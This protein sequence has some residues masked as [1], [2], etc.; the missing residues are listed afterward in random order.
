MKLK[1]LLAAG[2]IGAVSICSSAFAQSSVTLYGLI[3]TG[4]AY[5]TNQSGSHTYQT[6]NGTYQGPR[7]GL[8]GTEDLGGGTSAIFTLENGFSILNGNSLNQGREF[9]RQSFVGLSNTNWGTL[10]LGRQYDSVVDFLGLNTAYNWN[11]TINDNDNTFNNIRVQ[12]ALKYTTQTFK[13]FKAS[14]L[15]GFSNS[16]TGFNNNRAF[17]LG[18]SYTQGPLNWNV[19][20]AEYDSPYS[21]TNQTGAID[22]DYSAAYLTFNRSALKAH[23]YAS[24]QRIFGTGGV[25]SIG[26]L[27]LGALYTD[28]NYTYL[29]AQHLNV[30][31]F[32]L[33]AN[34]F[35]RPDILL[36]A[37][38][39]Y[40]VGQYTITDQ[41]PKWNEVNLVADYI[42]SKRTDIALMVYLQQ[43]GGGARADIE[44]YYASTT[45][46][47]LVTT[48]G[49]RHTF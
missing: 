38:Y 33:S 45:N 10:T 25:Y 6:A 36:G 24:K 31:N 43:A 29:D 44:G 9:G 37:A 8:R 48:L 3:S 16:A 39:V 40:T 7:W 15:Y 42:L 26:A 17:S 18:A 30:Q 21:A 5:S 34:Y 1:S 11:G 22:S 12:N 20:Y 13:G 4:L 19:A 27:K 14:A 46:R 32:S 2:G 23:A 28:V 47:Q 49:I 35:L 41:K